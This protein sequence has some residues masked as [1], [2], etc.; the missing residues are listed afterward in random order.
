MTALRDRA[1]E[2]VPVG[3][4][5]EAMLA[6]D[7]L[8]RRARGRA[9]DRGPGP[10]S[11]TSQELVEVAR[12]FDAARRGGRRHARRLP[13]AGLAG[14]RRRHAPRRRGPRDADDAAQR[15]GPRVPDR[16][17]HRRPRRASSR[18]RARSTRAR[19]RRSAGSATSASRAPC[20][21][22]PSR[23]RA[24]ARSS[25][26]RATGC[27][28]ASSTRSRPTCVEREGAP[29]RLLGGRARR[30][31]RGVGAA[32][33]PS[34]AAARTEAAERRTFR[35]GDDVV[36]AAF[37][38]G[39]VTGVEPGG[40]VVVRFAGDGSERKLM[41]EYAPD[42][43]A[44][45]GRRAHGSPDH[46]RQG[47]RR[48]RARARSR[49][50][51]PRSRPS[52]AARPG[53]ATILVGDDPAQRGLRRRQAEGLRARSASTA[54]TTG[55]PATRRATRS[56]RCIEQLNADD[57]VSGILCQLPVPDH[58]DGVELT[59]LDR[60]ATRTSTGSRR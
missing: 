37:G 28:A 55:C 43:E 18:T 36:H 4:L 20:A 50:T 49:A 24:G 11:R 15:Q 12:E 16:L 47:D 17:H 35:L 48:A 58:L 60:R 5:L 2:G 1:A 57:A 21:T 14:R 38:D 8:P 41:A 6:R 26:P 40:I 27:R 33:I 51:S 9:H 34:W 23:T 30:R 39:V 44:A 45:E 42:H 3:D 52:T 46:R 25:A 10:R 19:S 56:S 29:G 53:L 7:R 31:H 32:R 54:S 59:G 22:S 13:A